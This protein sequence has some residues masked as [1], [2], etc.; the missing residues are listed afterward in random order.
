MKTQEK[1]ATLTTAI[2]GGGK[3]SEQHLKALQDISCAEVVG[4]CDLSPALAE[5][6]AKRFSLPN[7]YTDH[8]IMLAD[9]SLDIIHVYS[10]GKP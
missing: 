2:I 5:F 10:P 3:I 1:Q 9:N 7:W 6:T 4:I 8:H